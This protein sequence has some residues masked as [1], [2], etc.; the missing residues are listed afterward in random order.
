MKLTQRFI[1]I[2][3]A[4]LGGFLI[5]LGG[6]AAGLD[7]AVTLVLCFLWGLAMVPLFGPNGKAWR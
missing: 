5:G 3:S 6:E 2:G 4:G 1:W 7:Y